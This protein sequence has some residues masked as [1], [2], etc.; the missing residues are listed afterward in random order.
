MTGH[1]DLILR[2][3]R[4]I[5]GSGS[6]AS[7]A[8]VAIQGECIAAI[9]RLDGARARREIDVSG[10]AVA[11][12]FIDTHTH[13]DAEVLVRPEMRA[14]VSQGVTSVIVGNCGISAAPASRAAELMGSSAAGRAGFEHFADYLGALRDRPGAVN[15]GALVGHSSLRASVMPDITR[16]A[17]DSEIGAMRALLSDALAAGALGISTGTFY[18]PARAATT[19]EIIRVCAP[20]RGAGGIFTTHMRD[21]ADGVMASLEETAA[22]GRAL[23]VPVVISHHKCAGVR[24]HG[25]SRETLAAIEAMAATQAVGMDVYPYDASSTMLRADRV[26]ISQRTLI[27]HCARYPEVVGRDARELAQERGC[28]VEALC[29]ALHP[30]GATYFMLSEDDVRRI[31]NHDLAMIGSDGVNDQPQPHPRLWGTFPRVLGRYARDLGLMPL[32][33]A[34]HKMTGLPA[35]RF[36][37]QRRG[38]LREG[39]FAD[40][41]VFDPATVR[42]NATYENPALPS[43]GILHVFTNG[44]PVWEDSV[45]TGQRAGRLLGRGAGDGSR[46]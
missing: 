17:S 5:D 40:I 12:G 2:G 35:Q 1:Y 10:M 44:R 28:T 37:L 27:T 3:G 29:E 13:D 4:V 7:R 22:I 31:L 34:V 25:R 18:P 45:P 11:P 8:D 38:L 24:N 30:A 36:G 39:W 32:E 15:V 33:R 26:R 6:V 41:T 20:L 9:G 23:G 46:A 42:D 21:E 43:S 19:D 16:S 14:K